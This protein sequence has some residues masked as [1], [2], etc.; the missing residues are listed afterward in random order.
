MADFGIL[1]RGSS[2]AQQLTVFFLIQNLS[3]AGFRLSICK[4]ISSK[5]FLVFLTKK[6]EP[7]SDLM[8]HEILIDYRR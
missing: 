7:Q 1:F 5:A 6:Q 3:L 8:K 4:F 2:Q